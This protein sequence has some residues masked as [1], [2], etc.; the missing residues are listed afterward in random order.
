MNENEITQLETKSP[1]EILA[2]C[3][4]QFSNRLTLACSLGAED[5]VLVDMLCKLT[6]GRGNRTPTSAPDIFVLDT[7]RLHQET[8]ATLQKLRE[9]YDVNI[10]I[11]FPDAKKVEKLVTQKGPNSFYESIENRKE[12][13]FIRKVEPLERKLATVDAWITGLRRDQNVTRNHIPKIEV[14]TSHGNIYKINPLAD[15]TWQQV[16]DYIQANGVPYN[17]LHD[18]GFPSIGCAPCTRAIQAGED[19]RA[20]RWWWEHAETKECGLHQS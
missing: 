9:R 11:L 19:P 8:Y 1:Q 2:F 17:I 13:C 16:W 20:G 3:V 14:D 7:G 4:K 18:R 12:C 15:W 5:V 6:K 10:E